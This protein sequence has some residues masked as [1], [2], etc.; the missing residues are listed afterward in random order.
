PCCDG[1]MARSVD[2]LVREGRKQ[3][4]RGGPCRRVHKLK[5]RRGWLIL[6]R[7]QDN[8]LLRLAGSQQTDR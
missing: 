7:D 3:S 2:L 8:G 5:R 6:R 4:G 1:M